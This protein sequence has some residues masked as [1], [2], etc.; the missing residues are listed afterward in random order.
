[1]IAKSLD[2]IGNALAKRRAYRRSEMDIYELIKQFG[3]SPERH[4]RVAAAIMGNLNARRGIKHELQGCD[5]D[6]IEE[7]F[8]TVARLVA[9]TP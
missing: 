4:D 9:D 1:M 7:I 8:H 3:T 5:G 6:V 2:K